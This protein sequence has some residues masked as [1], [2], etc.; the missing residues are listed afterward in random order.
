MIGYSGFLFT[1]YCGRYAN[2]GGAHYFSLHASLSSGQRAF[3][4]E[5]IQDAHKS[6][7]A[8]V[9]LDCFAFYHE[10]FHGSVPA[11]RPSRG[12][13]QRPRQPGLGLDSTGNVGSGA[14]KSVTVLDK[15][16]IVAYLL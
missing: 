12:H 10:L 3:L 13:T 2:S 5:E 1:G 6:C 14:T 9:G 16:R 11:M 8:F 15:A 7:P 4:Q